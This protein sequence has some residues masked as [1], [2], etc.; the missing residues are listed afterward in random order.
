MI[1]IPRASGKEPGL[2]SSPGAL[3]PAHR[4]DLPALRLPGS[5]G[6]I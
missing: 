1:S 6:V 4:V 3:Y 5:F 2:I